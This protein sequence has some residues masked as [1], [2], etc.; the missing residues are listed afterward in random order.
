MVISYAYLWRYEHQAGKQEGRKHRPAV[1][2][3]A[4]EK[5]DETKIVTVAPITHGE[6]R[7]L[8]NCV[9]IPQRVKQQLGLDHKKSWV[10]L[11]EV[12]QFAWPGY[13]LGRVIS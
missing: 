6:P 4:I 9:E 3:L 13:D 8:S 5:Q 11:S 10:I 7:D 1:I 2:V 12:N